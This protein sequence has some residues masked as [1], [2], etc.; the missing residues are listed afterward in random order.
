MKDIDTA[1]LYY[2][3]LYLSE[4]DY[5]SLNKNYGDLLTD[6]IDKENYETKKNQ[7]VSV[8]GEEVKTTAYS[9]TLNGEDAYEF[10]K[11]YI[12]LIQKDDTFKKVI[13]DKY[14]VLRNYI[15][16]YG[17]AMGEDFSSELPELK[18]SEID[19][20][21]TKLLE[22]LEDAKDEF[23]D[24]KNAIKLTIYSNKK[25]EPVKFEIAILEDKDDEEGS[26]IFTEELSKGKN[27]YTFD[28]KE[29]G[30]LVDVPSESTNSSATTDITSVSNSVSSILNTLSEITIE[31]KYETDKNSRKGT[32]T[33]AAKASGEKQDLLTIEYE[34]IN[35]ESQL[36][37]SMSLSSPLLSAAS[38]D[39]T[40]DITGLNTDKQNYKFDFSGKYSA[41]SIKLSM[42]GSMTTG[43]SDIPELTSS[44]SVDIFASSMEDL[45][46]V[47]TD[48]ITKAADTLP[49]KLSK[50]GVTVTKEEILSSLPQQTPEITDPTTTTPDGTTSTTDPYAALTEEQKK[51]IEQAQQQAQQQLDNMQLTDE[52]KKQLEQA[53]QQ[54][55]QQ[56]NKMQ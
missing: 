40:Y 42:N 12:E 5:N 51:Q 53:Q 7:K 48:V 6:L 56:L 2:D 35:S 4:E 28:L 54:V 19:S 21:L 34:N 11:K 17:E 41:Y 55:Q 30:D 25:S 14:D 8:D 18:T 44:N 47:Y 37:S 24:I 32:I 13:T 1:N 27:V 3:L 26:V 43:K 38:L 20:E 45:E 49:A 15:S 52:Q 22:D 50:Y 33:I 23:T 29:L 16:S 36:K 10:T 39:Y 46:K 31:D 9:L